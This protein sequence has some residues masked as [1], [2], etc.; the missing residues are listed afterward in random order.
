[1][2]TLLNVTGVDPLDD[3]KNNTRYPVAELNLISPVASWPFIALDREVLPSHPRI[4]Y[5]DPDNF[6]PAESIVGSNSFEDILSI[7]LPPK[8]YITIAAG[9]IG[10]L[11]AGILGEESSSSAAAEA[12]NPSRWAEAQ[13]EPLLSS[14]AIIAFAVRHESLQRLFKTLEQLFTCTI[15]HSSALRTP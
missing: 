9:G 8:Q 4:L 2:E 3:L 14:M 13:L 11:A 1:M 7:T 12:Y 5:K 6:V 15:L 10:D